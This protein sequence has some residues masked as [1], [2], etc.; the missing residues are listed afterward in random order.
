MK[1]AIYLLTSLV[2]CLSALSLVVRAVDDNADYLNPSLTPD[3]RAVDLLARMTLDEKIGQM[4]QTDL[5]CVTNLADIQTY[6]FGSM[7]SGGDS[8]PKSEN[9]PENWF[10]TV[11][12]L[13]SY[14]LKTRL[15]IPM[16][17][18]IDAVHG[19]NDVIGTTIFPHHIGMGATH[20][21]AL[22]EQADHVTA[23]EVAGTG[24]RWA[25]A[26]CIAVT[27]DERW[28]RTYESFGQDTKLVSDMGVASIK[29]LQGDSLSG[30]NDSVLACAKHYIGDGG[31]EDGVDQGNTV[32]D[33]KT[34]RKLFL[35]PYEAAIQ[36]GV[37]SIMVSYSSW[38]GVK[39]SG[40]KY[41][42]TDVLK[43]E[44]HFQGFL[45]SDWAAIDQLSP[46]YKSDVEQS[47]NAGLDM[48]MIPIGP[49][50]TNNYVEF[51]NDLKDLV[52]DGKVPQSRIDDAV[53]RILRVKF[54]MGLFENAWTDPALTSQIGSLEHRQVARECV[55]ESLVLLKNKHHT[56][57]LKKNIQHLVVVGA[58]A[59]NLGTQCGGWTISWQGAG[60]LTRGTTILQSIRSL[61]SP[62]TQITFSPDGSGITKADAVIVVVGE[63][64]YAEFKGDRTNLDL[65]VHDAALI[66]KAKASGAPVTTILLS[67]RPLILGDALGSS[68]AFV[69][70][71]LPGTE[72]EG[73]ADV[74]FGD[75]KFTGKLPRE[76]P[77][78]DKQ[79]AADKMHGWP[80][81]SV[82][83]GLTY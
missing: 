37:G 67:G 82:G 10:N 83:Y 13:Q 6:G 65:S 63:R 61:V 7:L 70:A 62:Q 1:P 34:L 25:F 39:M 81:F 3:A 60:Q 29:G 45:V 76:W 69:A 55:R 72:G 38:N 12:N 19:H 57:P 41:L 59:N 22:M 79:F 5:S 23:L 14:A 50:R 77:R 68:D 80:L 2:C 58:A 20:D 18:G 66:A 44:L 15:K 64:P 49:G 24:I 35:P 52:A 46:D 17:Y 74:L 30:K 27:Q 9:A 4:V 11:N 36:A 47:I 26:P 31:T 48:I 75:A 28:G 53:L 40:N 56:L 78:N 54:Q 71:W 32:C 51:I 43:T 8:K 73:V 42:L 33:E 16:I 21:P